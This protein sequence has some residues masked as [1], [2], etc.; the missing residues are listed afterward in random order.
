MGYQ[1][2]NFSHN[3]L[4]QAILNSNMNLNV[5]TPISEPEKKPVM[6]KSKSFLTRKLTKK[7]GRRKSGPKDRNN[8]SVSPTHNQIRR[9]VSSPSLSGQVNSF[10]GNTSKRPMS[11]RSTLPVLY[12]GRLYDR[13]ERRA[14][15]PKSIPI[16]RKP[17]KSRESSSR[18]NSS[19]SNSPRSRSTP[20]ENRGNPPSEKPQGGIRLNDITFLDILGEGTYGQV[21]LCRNNIDGQI[22]CC[23]ILNNRKIYQYKQID[24]VKQEN[25]VLKNAQH[26]GIVKFYGTFHDEENIYFFMEYVPGG[27]LFDYMRKQTRLDHDAVRFYSAELIVI[28]EYLHEYDIAYRDIKPENIL[29]DIDGHLKLTDFGFAKRVRGRTYTMCG[30]A[31]Y[32]APEVMSKNGYDKSVDWWAMGCLIFEMLSGHT[33]FPNGAEVP[34][35]IDYALRFPDYFEDEAKDL[36][37]RLLTDPSNRLGRNGTESIKQHPFFNRINW[38]SIYDRTANPPIQPTLKH[39]E[40]GDC[41]DMELE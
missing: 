39:F 7:R 2:L 31:E 15:T 23:K 14:T 22:Y 24:H 35:N 17:L 9:N 1:N 5:N 40:D 3:M 6:K 41:N 12:Q 29:L 27:E 16:S 32:I 18:S 30:T 10:E 34:Y 4:T 26:P 36:L 28:L 21:R 37:S 11:A 8:R 33:P 25:W 20:I 19:R 38:A 13:N